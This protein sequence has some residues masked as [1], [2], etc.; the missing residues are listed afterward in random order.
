MILSTIGEGALL[1]AGERRSRRDRLAELLDF[2]TEHFLNDAELAQQH[3]QNLQ[4]EGLY[5][6]QYWV[7]DDS[8]QCLAAN[9][10]QH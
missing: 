3:A 1:V 2:A 5:S 10:L 6:E 8:Q 4:I 7:S 9:T